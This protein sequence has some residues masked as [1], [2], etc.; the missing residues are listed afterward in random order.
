MAMHAFCLGAC[1]GSAFHCTSNRGTICML[2]KS[3]FF[4]SWCA[5]CALEVSRGIKTLSAS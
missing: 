4:G 1:L 5:L 2:G 3:L